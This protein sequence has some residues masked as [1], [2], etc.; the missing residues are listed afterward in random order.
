MSNKVRFTFDIDIQEMMSSKDIVK[1]T[2]S[3]YSFIDHGIIDCDDDEEICIDQ[4]YLADLVVG[5]EA[6]RKACNK[7]GR[8][9]D[10][11]VK[12]PFKEA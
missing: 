6:I 2:E 1:L 10:G 12:Y 7:Y 3:L 5:I 11:L 4:D 9:T 8:D